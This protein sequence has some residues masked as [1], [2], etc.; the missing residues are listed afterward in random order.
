[1]GGFSQTKAPVMATME[2][3]FRL[4]VLKDYP[5]PNVQEVAEEFVAA[6]E[7]GFHQN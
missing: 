1:M 2:N 5:T 7:N 6:L 4:F 3:N